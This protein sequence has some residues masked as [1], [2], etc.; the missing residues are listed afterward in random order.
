MGCNKKKYYACLKIT[1]YTVRKTG[2]QVGFQ[3]DSCNEQTC[4]RA[5]IVEERKWFIDGKGFHQGG[6]IK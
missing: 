4:G 5:G 3:S 2:Q 6:L 1:Y